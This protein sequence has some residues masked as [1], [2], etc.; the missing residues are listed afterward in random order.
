MAID[1]SDPVKFSRGPRSVTRWNPAPTETPLD[2]NHLTTTFETH[3]RPSPMMFLGPPEQLNPGPP[4][5]QAISAPDSKV[6]VLVDVVRSG[7]LD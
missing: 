1:P 4:V 7:Y 5:G 3:W 2:R 6:G